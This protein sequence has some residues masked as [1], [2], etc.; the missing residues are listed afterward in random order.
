MNGIAAA[1]AAQRRAL[2]SRGIGL[3]RRLGRHR[4][5][6]G[7]DRPAAGADARRH[8]P[9]AYPVPDLHPRRRR[10]DGEP[11]QR[12]ARQVDDDAAGRAGAGAGRADRPLSRRIRAS[13]APASSSRAFSMCP[14]APRSLTIHA[15]CQSLLRRFPLEAGVPPEF[16]VLDE[17]SAGEAL[18][19][20]VETVITAARAG[21]AGE[22]PIWPRRW[23][24]S[25]ATPPRSASPS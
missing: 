3:G 11:G 13:P 15:F 20:A 18:A 19:E 14:A 10:R 17:R 1:R 2:R 24:S 21:A 5:D 25:P 9:G 23:R 8:R 4:Q 6:Q 12:P 7:A 16:A 22:R